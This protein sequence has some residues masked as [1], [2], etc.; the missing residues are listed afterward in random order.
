MTERYDPNAWYD[1]ELREVQ[2]HT[3]P[4][5]I[6]TEP[7]AIA[8]ERAT[9]VGSGTDS[10]GRVVQ[11]YVGTLA[12]ELVR[13]EE[14]LLALKNR[15]KRMEEDLRRRLQYGPTARELRGMVRDACDALAEMS[16]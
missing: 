9:E 16:D 5:G 11:K 6:S 12:Q 8:Q 1:A 15:C 10:E 2:T 13:V 7:L 4:I 3:Q 14:E